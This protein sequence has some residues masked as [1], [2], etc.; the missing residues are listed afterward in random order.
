[1]IP[2]LVKFPTRQRPDRFRYALELLVKHSVRPQ[3]LHFLFT[4]DDDDP[5]RAELVRIIHRLCVAPFT[6]DIPN[7]NS[8]SKINAVNRDVPE[9][10]Q[11]WANVI[12]ASDDMH[13]TP[14]WDGWVLSAMEHF[15]PEGD[16]Y[17]WF[18]D[19]HQF[20]ICT[21]PCM[22][23]KYFDRFGYIYNPA[24]KSVFVDDEQTHLANNL[25]RMTKIDHILFKHD[26]PAWNS[27]LKPDALYKKN[28]APAVWAHDEAIYRKRHAAG[29][30]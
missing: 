6:F 11:G 8:T 28:E 22:D 4:I 14:A 24:Y 16:G 30:P 27:S 21:I 18:S 12:V 17:L 15:Y 29:F 13:A 9:F 19:G 1:M 5:K 3:D 20:D 23:R 25:G 26:H 2:L 10:G 7:G